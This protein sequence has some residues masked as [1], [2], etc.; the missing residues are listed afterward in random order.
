[1]NPNVAGGVYLEGVIVAGL[2]WKFA[3]Q[4]QRDLL[5]RAGA[6]RLAGRFAGGDR[7]DRGQ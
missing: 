2:L 7:A 3:T 1:M 6:G 5:L 4:A